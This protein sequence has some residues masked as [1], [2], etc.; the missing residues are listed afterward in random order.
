[1]L[2]TVDRNGN[3]HAIL[4]KGERF[5][6]PSRPYIRP[7]LCAVGYAALIFIPLRAHGVLA[8]SLIQLA[9]CCCFLALLILLLAYRNEILRVVEAIFRAC[10][11]IFQCLVPDYSSARQQATDPAITAEPLRASLFQRPPPYFA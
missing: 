10:G 11:G 7:C 2:I 9:V 6:M 5:P 4:T 8:S 1:M 3:L